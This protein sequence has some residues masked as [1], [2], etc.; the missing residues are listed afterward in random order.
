M[1][2]LGVLEN[3]SGGQQVFRGQASVDLP[4]ILTQ[5][6]GTVDVTL[7]GL[8]PGDL[9][10]VSPSAALTTGLLMDN[11]VKV[12]VA[13]TVT[14][15]ATNASAGTINQAAQTMDFEVWRNNVPL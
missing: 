6:S 13:D 9:V 8:L 14:V 7:T 15:R 11:P 4:S 10:F 5:V 2:A 3:K 1:A 12:T